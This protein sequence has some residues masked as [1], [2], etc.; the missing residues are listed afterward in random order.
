M[1]DYRNH[2]RDTFLDTLLFKLQISPNVCE[3]TVFENAGTAISHFP[4]GAHYQGHPS[5]VEDTDGHASDALANLLDLLDHA[6][7]LMIVSIFNFRW[8]PLQT[9][10][11]TLYSFRIL[12]V[13]MLR[14][15]LKVLQGSVTDHQDPSSKRLV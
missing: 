13:R 8:I 4:H 12:R 11:A 6:V 7:A 3:Q 14:M 5:K 9:I 10:L 15:H 1:Q 2:F